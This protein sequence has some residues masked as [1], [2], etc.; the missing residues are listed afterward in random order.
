MN[1]YSRNIPLRKIKFINVYKLIFELVLSIPKNLLI[2]L[3]EKNVQR[4]FIWG[5]GYVFTSAR[6]DSCFLESE[7]ELTKVCWEVEKIITD[8]VEISSLTFLIC[9]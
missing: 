2:K 3:K 1:Q 6:L 9:F 8:Y 4:L 7:T 5:I